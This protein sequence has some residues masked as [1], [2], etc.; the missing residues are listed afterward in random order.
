M[1]NSTKAMLKKI[2][3]TSTDKIGHIGA[4]DVCHISDHSKTGCSNVNISYHVY[5]M[6]IIC[7]YYMCLDTSYV[8]I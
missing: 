1:M 6:H 8:L 7:V 3:E 4:N 2:A 5:Y